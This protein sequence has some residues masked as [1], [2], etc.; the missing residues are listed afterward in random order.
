MDTVVQVH[1]PRDMLTARLSLTGHSANVCALAV[2]EAPEGGA[3]LL[4]SSSWDHTARLWDLA[5]GACLHVLE[6]HTAT[7]WG[8][9]FLDHGVVAT[10]GAD[11]AVRLWRDGACVGVINGH[12][13]P[14]RAVAALPGIGFVTASNDW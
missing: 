9:A 5:S 6:G 3:P 7:V 10:A 1:E 2:G 8:A 11:K 12:A 13:G 4:V 14:V